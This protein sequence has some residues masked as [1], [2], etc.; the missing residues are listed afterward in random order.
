MRP[1]RSGAVLGLV[2]AVWA[3]ESS[4]RT[5]EWVSDES[6]RWSEVARWAGRRL[7]LPVDDVI[8]DRP[9]AAP[10]ILFDRAPATVNSIFS[11]ERFTIGS[12]D[13]PQTIALT[14]RR[15]SRFLG[16]VAGLCCVIESASSI[17]FEGEL[18]VGLLTL[19]GRGVTR[20]S[21]G[22]RW[23]DT[24]SYLRL[25]QGHTFENLGRIGVGQGSEIVFFEGGVFRN[26]STGTIEITGGRLYTSVRRPN[27]T[28]LPTWM[29]N[30][31][32]LRITSGSLGVGADVDF[33]S[34]GSIFIEGGSVDAHGTFDG[35]IR[36]GRGGAFAGSG[37]FLP[38]LRVEA[39][40]GAVWIGGLE[41]PGRMT[42]VEA[43][44]ATQT[45]GVGRGISV[46]TGRV[47]AP[48]IS[49]N[50]F[51]AD[52]RFLSPLSRTRH[53]DIREG[54]ARFETGETIFLE[55]FSLDYGAQR[56]GVDTI[57]VSG[58]M[59]LGPGSLG[60]GGRTHARG[61]IVFGT[62]TDSFRTVNV[63]DG[64]TLV[65]HGNGRSAG[66][67]FELHLSPGAA[68]V[69]EGTLLLPGFFRVVEREP[70]REPGGAFRNEGVIRQLPAE[71]GRPD[72]DPVRASVGVWF[73]NHGQVEVA[74]RGILELGGGGR[75]TGR[76]FV[77][78][79]GVLG[80]AGDHEI[81]V[82]AS[83]DATDAMVSFGMLGGL[84]YSGAYTIRGA[85]AAGTTLVVGHA[86][87][88]GVMPEFGRLELGSGGRV[89]LSNTSARA[90]LGVLVSQGGTVIVDRD[91]MLEVGSDQAYVQTWI[92]GRTHIDGQLSSPDIRF[93]DGR[94][95]GD[96]TLVGGV[97]SGGRIEPGAYDLLEPGFGTFGTLRIDGDFRQTPTGV[98]ALDVGGET[99]GE[100]LDAVRVSGRAFLD[101][102]LQVRL[103]AD[104][105]PT[106]GD[107]F[108]LV[109]FGSREG[110][111]EIELAGARDDGL[112]Y[113]F[114]YGSDRLSMRVV[115]V[116]EPRTWLM[117]TVGGILMF[118]ARR[119]CVDRSRRATPAAPD[120][121]GA[122]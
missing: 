73:E 57:E 46:F 85:Y 113:R 48:A 87:F 69:N 19:R 64:H 20:A 9:D 63:L 119:R 93:D 42:R 61:G 70:W 83:V 92:H 15:P 17:D 71:Q 4:G 116:P 11:T 38:T 90:A 108:D 86:S 101:G 60:G 104:F 3:G 67:R 13:T 105:A 76:F 66:E 65:N 117:I 7:P 110:S 12:L 1:L 98:I 111:L 53:L 2:V 120:T 72:W 59:Y 18:S 39:E 122:G 58:A 25:E 95:S 5:V 74:G 106:A 107:V 89:T 41:G 62:E 30:D 37:Q 44:L 81:E 23:L 27:S 28:G 75:S 29:R 6:G 43:S 8:I 55:T 31:G 82:G 50:G 97:S 36:V 26:A 112:L 79:G 22:V 94:L 51:G 54:T 91:S 88:E 84:P 10:E 24:W 33:R 52:A 118:G 35:L 96:G 14:L 45:L 40:E 114:E 32:V 16:P 68:F 121:A 77:G 102:I 115:A 99:P 47:D 49:V 21:G 100:N 103:T 56:L 78:R 109:W 34:T 80:L